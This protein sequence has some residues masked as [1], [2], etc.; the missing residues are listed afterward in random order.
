MLSRQ[1]IAD[2][3]AYLNSLADRSTADAH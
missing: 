1:Q 2:I 3:T